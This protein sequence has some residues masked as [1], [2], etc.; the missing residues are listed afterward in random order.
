MIFQ[1]ILGRHLYK[2]K[3]LNH[4]IQI[5]LV[6]TLFVDRSH[7]RLKHLLHGIN[8]GTGIIMESRAPDGSVAV[9]QEN[10][11]H[12]NRQVVLQVA[13]KEQIATPYTLK[14]SKEKRPLFL[15]FLQNKFP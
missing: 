1:Y 11:V 3:R 13:K 15:P 6:A 2:K 12:Q 5:T 4:A 8:Y 14:Q 7:I 9:E 10:T